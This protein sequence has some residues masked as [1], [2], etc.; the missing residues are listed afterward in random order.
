MTNSALDCAAQEAI[1]TPEPQ[2]AHRL[3]PSY[4]APAAIAQAQPAPEK[5]PETFS[6]DTL[7][8]SS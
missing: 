1:R 2:K 5:C 8:L 4:E 7:T 6:F 3:P